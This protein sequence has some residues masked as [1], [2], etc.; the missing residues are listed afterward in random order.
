MNKR[1]F[2]LVELIAVIS[3]LSILMLLITPAIT[4]YLNQAK[5]DVL[6]L[7]TEGF[8]RTA[9]LNQTDLEGQLF[10]I[11]SGELM[12]DGTDNV[13]DTS[14]GKNENGYVYICKS[15]RA[16]ASIIDGKSKYCTLKETDSNNI[17][18]IK[19]NEQKCKIH[20]DVDC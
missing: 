9:R 20:Y 7:S 2:T 8:I 11:D 10:K 6:K 18:V 16:A 15:G 5:K 19:Y 14:K 12:I 13:L 17:I 4:N 3:I 1:G